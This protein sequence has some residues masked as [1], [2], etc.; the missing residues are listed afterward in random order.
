MSFLGSVNLVPKIF[1]KQRCACNKS[2]RSCHKDSKIFYFAFF[3]KFLSVLQIRCLLKLALKIKF[4]SMPLGFSFQSLVHVQVPDF[5]SS[6]LSFTL[7]TL[8]RSKS[9]QCHP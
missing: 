6:S 9:L 7:T 4:T 1:I 3:Y 5:T 8:E 2:Y